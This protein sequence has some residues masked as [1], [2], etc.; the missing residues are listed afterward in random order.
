M[1]GS[2]HEF[3][4]LKKTNRL[5]W[6]QSYLT[7]VTD[8]PLDTHTHTRELEHAHTPAHTHTPLYSLWAAGGV[9][10]L[11]GSP[12]LLSTL[13]HT[14]APY[15][16]CVCSESSSNRQCFHPQLIQ[17][18]SKLGF[19]CEHTLQR[20]RESLRAELLEKQ[21]LV[22]W[23]INRNPSNV[24]NMFSQRSVSSIDNV[25]VF[26]ALSHTIW[27]FWVCLGCSADERYVQC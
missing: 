15:T 5:H 1:N 24:P 12:I 4:Y 6:L 22:H 3:T 26:Q 23:E 25:L 2:L 7:A 9:C 8:G 18:Y 11:S 27:A 21:E 16:V 14:I 10:C 17:P 20:E 13:S 19:C